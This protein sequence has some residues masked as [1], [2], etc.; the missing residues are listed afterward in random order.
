MKIWH[1][2]MCVKDTVA[3]TVAPPSVK[4][5]MEISIAELSS[6]WYTIEIFLWRSQAFKPPELPNIPTFILSLTTA[7]VCGDPVVDPQQI[8]LMFI[9]GL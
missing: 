7:C 8:P 9:P 4:V 1:Q 2:G 5:L 6:G 3:C